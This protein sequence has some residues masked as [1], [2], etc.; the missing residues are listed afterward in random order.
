MQIMKTKSSSPLALFV[1]KLNNIFKPD[2]LE[3]SLLQFLGLGNQSVHSSSAACHLKQCYTTATATFL[4]WLS[5]DAANH[6]FFLFFR[7]HTIIIL[8][9]LSILTVFVPEPASGIVEDLVTSG[10][11]LHFTG[12]TFA[13]TIPRDLKDGKS[14][15][16]VVNGVEHTVKETSILDGIVVRGRAGTSP[17]VTIVAEEGRQKEVDQTTESGKHQQVQDEGNNISQSWVFSSFIN[18]I[19]R[20]T[21]VPKLKCLKSFLIV[22]WKCYHNAPS[23]HVRDW[24]L[25]N[26]A[27][28]RVHVQLKQPLDD[29][30]GF[31][32]R[33]LFVWRHW[34][35][36]S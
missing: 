20:K 17:T 12:N 28:H 35:Q 14:G 1:P 9:V 24:M 31:Q 8:R 15:V 25:P 7:G 16:D 18:E 21:W 29:S 6:R 30:R 33:N 22:I 32:Y 3:I 23:Y 34:R 2:I 10:S 13:A 36:R 26:R 27:H 4:I 19:E 5:D 11:A